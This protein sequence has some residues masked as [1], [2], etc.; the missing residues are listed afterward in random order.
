MNW[1]KQIGL[2][3][4]P[5]ALAMAACGTAELDEVEAASGALV[6]CESQ[7]HDDYFDFEQLNGNLALDP[8]LKQITGLDTV[9][10]CEDART[11]MEQV[12]LH[13]EAML[14][15]DEGML[16][17][18]VTELPDGIGK[19]VSAIKNA[20]GTNQSQAGVLEIGGGCTGVLITSRAILT[21]AHC[22]DQLIAPAKNGWANLSIRRYTPS[23]TLVYSGQV[24]INVHPNYSGDG[25]T[26]DDVAVIK[27]FAPATF[28]LPS[29]HRTRIYVGAGSTIGT[30]RLYGRGF[31]NG[32]GTGSSVLRYMNFKP[33]WWGPYHYLENAGNARVC[34]GDSGGP[35]IDW[36]P[37]G[38][39][40]VAGLHSNSQKSLTSGVCARWLGKQRSVRL[41]HK[42]SWIEDMLDVTCH[43]FNDSGWSYVRCW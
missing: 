28:G 35:T 27:L 11:Y 41:Q 19:S 39:R 7:P 40:V 18:D 42:I 14:P 2:L 30:M 25:D 3:M 29:S 33:D 24:R 20:N 43:S 32:N 31:S 36:S 16:V 38:Y 23:E 17:E 4:A 21:A 13:N 37:N 10:S 9:E 8:Q 12:N 6:K 34:N 26:G 22:V 15:T 1:M 5:C